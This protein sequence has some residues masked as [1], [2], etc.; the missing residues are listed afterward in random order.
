MCCRSL[1][2]PS[3]SGRHSAT[4]QKLAVQKYGKIYKFPAV[5]Y[6]GHVPYTCQPPTAALKLL[7]SSAIVF[8][9]KKTN[10]YF[11]EAAYYSEHLP[12]KW[13]T[14]HFFLPHPK[15]W[16]L[17]FW[18]FRRVQCCE[19]GSETAVHPAETLNHGVKGG[20]VRIEIW[21]WSANWAPSSKPELKASRGQQ[22]NGHWSLGAESCSDEQN[23]WTS[24]C[25]LLTGIVLLDF[26]C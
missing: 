20:G 9:L 17:H 11:Y 13:G 12:R 24:L 23:Q 5:P 3:A 7:P 16:T 19:D 26:V 22:S 25:Q 4:G 6:S 8:L 21:F 18:L 10:I 15:P 2:R 14:T 1:K